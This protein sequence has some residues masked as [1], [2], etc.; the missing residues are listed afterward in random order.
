MFA[1]TSSVDLV[2]ALNIH[3][4]IDIMDWWGGA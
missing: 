3:G 2:L 1:F 4:V